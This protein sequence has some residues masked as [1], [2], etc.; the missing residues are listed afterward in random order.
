MLFHLCFHLSE[1]VLGAGPSPMPGDLCIF[2]ELSIYDGFSAAS[3]VCTCISI[4]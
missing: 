3:D 1:M 4:P 2:C